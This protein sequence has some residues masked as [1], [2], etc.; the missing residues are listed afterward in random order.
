VGADV[1][2][3]GPA[4]RMGQLLP[5]AWARA[6]RAGAGGQGAEDRAWGRRAAGAR[7]LVIAHRGASA[8][9]LENTLEAFRLA[10]RQGADGVELDAMPCGTGEIVVFHDDDLHRLTGGRTERIAHMPLAAL[11]EITLLGKAGRGGIPLLDEVLEELGPD[12]L[13]NVELKTPDSMRAPEWSGHRLAAEV[14]ALLRRHGTGRRALVS[15]FNPVALARFRLAAP[16]APSGLLFAADQNLLLRHGWARM[17]LRPLALHPDRVLVTGNALARW[18]L[19]GYA[20]NV[21]TVDDEAEIARLCALGVDGIITN[22]PARTRT[23][24]R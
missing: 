12:L 13:V 14:A 5:L 7:P 23:L 24:L 3:G 16:F 2:R 8:G 4:E 21:W 19:E 20:V 17:A 6:R 15:S 10:R 1:R 18:R 11:R 9:A 22:D